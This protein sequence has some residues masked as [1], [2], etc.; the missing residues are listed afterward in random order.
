MSFYL[1]SNQG[2]L[3][4]ST[5]A[6]RTIHIYWWLSDYYYIEKTTQPPSGG[7][8]ASSCRGKL[9]LRCWAFA[10]LN[11]CANGDEADVNTFVQTRKSQNLYLL[12]FF[13]KYSAIKSSNTKLYLKMCACVGPRWHNFFT[14]FLYPNFSLISVAVWFIICEI[15]HP[16][17]WFEARAVASLT[18]PGGQ[19]FHF[20]HF[21]LKF[22]SIFLIFPQ[23][24][25]I[26]FLILALRVGE[27]PTR[28]GPGYATVWSLPNVWICWISS[29]VVRLWYFCV[30]YF[31]RYHQIWILIVQPSKFGSL[32]LNR[33][34]SE[35]YVSIFV[36]CYLHA[37]LP[38]TNWNSLLAMCLY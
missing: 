2:I 4:L 28:E 20:P 11:D 12:N 38:F 9:S 7:P 27:S 34:T 14:V 37:S 13:W 10:W 18:V 6:S 15:F 3:M 25:P 32:Q 26:F 30:V 1:W 29:I 31:T 24:L 5:Y 21:F 33:C 19:E 36:V 16:T 23:T 22:R 17:E 8:G 35:L